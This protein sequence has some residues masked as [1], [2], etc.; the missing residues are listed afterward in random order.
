MKE[1]EMRKEIV[2]RLEKPNPKQVNLSNLNLQDAELEE[3]FIN[4]QMAKPELEDIFINNNQVTDIGAVILF[5]YLKLMPHLKLI[6][7]QFNELNEEGIR[8]LFA[9]KKNNQE[10]AFAFF[11]NHLTDAGKMYEIEKLYDASK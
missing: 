11:G 1:M 6:D 2:E 5:K 3:I 4:I 8:H 7:L 9:L 10:I